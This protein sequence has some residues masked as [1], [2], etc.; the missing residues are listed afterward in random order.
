MQRSSSP[1][2]W[3]AL[4]ILLLLIP[5]T[6]GRFLLDILGGLTLLVLLLPL[7]AGGVGLLAWQL[8][9]RRLNTCD[10]CG[11]IS[12]GM[13]VCPACGSLLGDQSPRPDGSRDLEALD[14]SQVIINVEAVDLPSPPTDRDTKPAA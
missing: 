11:T 2:L 13:D 3:V 4:A 14:P 1:W 12:F 9:R 5:G 6:A 7:I 10:A 8:I